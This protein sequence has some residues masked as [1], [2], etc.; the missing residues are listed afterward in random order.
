[1]NLDDLKKNH[2][3][4]YLAEMYEKLLADEREGSEMAQDPSMR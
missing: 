4:A 3:M 2:K 1:M